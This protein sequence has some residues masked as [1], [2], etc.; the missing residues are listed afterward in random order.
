M[1]RFLPRLAVMAA[2]TGATLLGAPAAQAQ[3]RTVVGAGAGAVAGALVAGRSARWWAASSARPGANRAGA[4][5]GAPAGCGGTMGPGRSQ[6][7]RSRHAKSRHVG[8]GRAR[9]APAAVPARPRAWVD[10][11]EA[12]PSRLPA[13]LASGPEPPTSWASRTPPA[14]YPGPPMSRDEQSAVK[15][16]RRQ[17]PPIHGPEAFEAMRKAGR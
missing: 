1:T 2:L 3:S 16:G 11:A 13:S 17:E 14:S 6:H 12:G 10:R 4:R 15:D 8:A 5:G 9:R 7:A